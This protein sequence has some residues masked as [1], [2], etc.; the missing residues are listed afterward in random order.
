[1]ASFGRKDT[2]FVHRLMRRDRP[3]D[4]IRPLAGSPMYV[5]SLHMYDFRCFRKAVAELRYPGRVDVEEPVLPNVNLI[6]GNNGSGKSSVLRALAIAALAPVL[7]ES[8]FVAYRLVRRPNPQKSLVKI[9]A[10][11]TRE[12]ANAKPD[13]EIELLGRILARKGS[14]ID[15]LTSKSTPG[16]PVEDL[17]FQEKSPAFFVVGYGATRR[18]EAGEYSGSSALKSRGLRYQRVAGLFEDHVALRPLQ[19]WM[20]GLSRARFS[21]VRS[22]LNRVLPEDIRFTG[23]REGPDGPYLFQFRGDVTPFPGLSDGYRAYI[24]WVTDLLG[25]LADCCPAKRGLS[26]LSGLVLVDE[27]DLHLH[28]EWQRSVVPSFALAFPKLQFVLTS[29]SPIVVGTLQHSNLFLADDDADGMCTLHQLRE[30]VHGKSAEQLLLSSYF[31]LKSTRAPG[32]ELQ[33]ERLF[34]EAARGDR[35]A[36][37][38]YLRL[39]SEERDVSMASGNRRASRPRNVPRA[40]KKA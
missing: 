7:L 39:L 27:V 37:L 9:N 1:M 30:H 28:P 4:T 5:R 18:I 3:C 19:T 11:L 10:V 29:H 22:L 6:L 23:K 25:H 21:E 2:A 40:R 34:D 31:N 33:A 36:A 16:N 24:G 26:D 14:S 20:P 17:I 35:N 12:E 32:V 38:S 8:G 13:K 15:R